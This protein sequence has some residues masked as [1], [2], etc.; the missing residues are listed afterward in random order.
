MKASGISVYPNPVRETL[1]L[2][3][4]KGESGSVTLSDAV[5]RTLFEKQA[6]GMLEKIEFR[7]LPAG[8]YLL[9]VR[10]GNQHF[11]RKIRKE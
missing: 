9:K 8:S 10:A 6:V 7:E 11:I 4:G 1:F 2:E 5:G 3:F